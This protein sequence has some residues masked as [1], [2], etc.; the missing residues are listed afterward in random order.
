[1]YI[2]VYKLVL[3]LAGR[4]LGQGGELGQGV[5]AERGVGAR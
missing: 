2:V 5:G 4:E 1:M 3:R